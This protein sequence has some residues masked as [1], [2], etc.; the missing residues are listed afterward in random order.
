MEKQSFSNFKRR[1]KFLSAGLF[2]LVTCTICSCVYGYNTWVR[3]Y[4]D[5]Q[6]I[7]NITGIPFPEFNIVEYWQGPTSFNGD[8]SDTLKLEMKEPM[9][10]SAIQK[11]D[12]IISADTSRLPV[13][14]Q[15][16]NRYRF[17]K[18]WGHGTPAPKGE[19]DDEDMHFELLMDKGSRIVTIVFGYY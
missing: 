6:T 4:S 16:E 10:D 17:F 14:R 5:N 19:N 15:Y 9:S 3:R 13:W 8:F 11:L 7:E 12:S 1:R 18:T 2:V